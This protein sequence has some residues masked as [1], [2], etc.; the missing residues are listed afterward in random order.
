MPYVEL[1]KQHFMLV[2]AACGAIA[3]IA[4]GLFLPIRATPPPQGETVRWSLPAQQA[5]RRFDPEHYESL[6]TAGF[7]N[8]PPAASGAGKVIGWT[9]NAIMTKPIAQ[10]SVGTPGRNTQTWVRL[11]GTLPD[12][13]T[14][15]AINRDAV[16]YERDGCRRVKRM[17]SV[18]GSQSP[19]A[20]NGEEQPCA[21]TAPRVPSSGPAAPA[22][23]TVPEPSGTTPSNGK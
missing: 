23:N 20:V 2:A 11:G 12:G 9:L 14:L 10:V 6:K 18:T 22:S 15:V 7:W 3:G 1:A 4:I 8:T 5:I 21:G 19:T 16:S 17:Y 13:A